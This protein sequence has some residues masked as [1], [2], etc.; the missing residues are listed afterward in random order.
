MVKLLFFCFRVTNSKLK[1]K[2]FHFELLDGWFFIFSLSSHER[3]VDKWKKLFKYYSSNV[4]EPLE[5]D[6]TP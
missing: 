3:E 2:K 5:I 4:Y 1:N 6:I